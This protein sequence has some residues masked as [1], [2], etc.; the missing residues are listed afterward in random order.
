VPTAAELGETALL[1]GRSRKKY[2]AIVAA[3]SGILPGAIFGFLLHPSWER[4]LI[5]LAIGL[6]WGNAFEYSYHR[7]MLHRP[8]GAFAKGHLEH[9]MNVGTV[10]EPEHVALG[11]SPAH[12]A[13]LF[14]SNGVL[15]TPIDLF[16]GLHV[17]PGI[18]VGWAVYLIT[19]EDIHWRIHMNGWL[20]PGLRFAR[21]YHMSHHDYPN[22]RYNV[23]FPLFDLL[24]GNSGLRHKPTQ[25]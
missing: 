23:F 12:I 21:A 7:W 15:V 8:R 22:V 10:E 24:L 6:I 2:N 16:L 25:A 14:A 13:L 9:H 4:C 3:V 20:P 1:N 11:R 5:G 18:F 17:I 19:A